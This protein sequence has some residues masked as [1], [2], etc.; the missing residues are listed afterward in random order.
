MANFPVA[1]ITAAR[2][3][4]LKGELV[5]ALRVPFTPDTQADVLEQAASLRRMFEAEYPVSFT[6]RPL[7]EQ[8]ELLP[9]PTDWPT[10]LNAALAP[11]PAPDPDAP[12]GTT[13]ADFLSGEES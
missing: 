4:V 10:A 6:V 2:L 9:E 8:P 3:N 5:V 13:L 1:Q 11:P 7:Y 12:T